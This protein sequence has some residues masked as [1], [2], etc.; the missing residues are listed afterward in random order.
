M[1]KYI[2]I[3]ASDLTQEILNVTEKYNVDYLR[4]N[5]C[6]G[7]LTA[8]KYI[9]DIRDNIPDLLMSYYPYSETEILE[10]LETPEWQ[11]PEI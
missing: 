2:I 8:K 6:K 9:I 11:C 1:K 4:W 3:K 7:V 5:Q 10:I